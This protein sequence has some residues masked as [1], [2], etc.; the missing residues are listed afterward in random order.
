MEG[1]KAP[2]DAAKQRPFFYIMLDKEVFGQEQADGSFCHPIYESDGRLLSAAKIT[3]NVSDP[4]IFELLQTAEGFRKLVHSIGVSIETD[5]VKDAAFAFQLYGKVDTY[6]G[7]TNFTTKLKTDGVEV[8]VNLEDFPDS[9]DEKCPGQIRFNFF[10]K[11]VLAHVSVRLFLN[12]G[13]NAPEPVADNPVDTKSAA[14]KEMISHSL[15]YKGNTARLKNVMDRASKGE[16]VTLAYLGGSITQ[17]AGATPINTNCY[18]YKSFEKF[19]EIT[20]SGDNVR[21]VKAGV[22][23][24]P[25]EL[26]IVRFERDVIRD[27]GILPDMVVVE[28]AVN[29]AGDETKGD[30]FESLI[31]KILKLPNN[32]AVIILFAVFADDFNLQERLAPVGYRYHVPMVS[33]KNAVT[34]QFGLKPENGRVVSRSRYFYDCFHPTNIGHTIMSDSIACLFEAAMDSN[35]KDETEELLKGAPVIGNTFEDIVLTDKK[36]TCAYASINAGSF[37]ETDKVLQCVEK[38][39]DIKATP[40]FEFNW[41]YD[42]INFKGEYKP[43]ELEIECKSLMIVFKDSGDPK[44]GV[45]KAVVDGE[46]EIELD[47]HISGWVHCNP[48]ILTMGNE[49]R[50]HNV[51]LIPKEGSER[52]LFTILGFGYTR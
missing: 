23:G 16:K 43:F 36:A 7:G 40:E 47:P 6:G 33:V 35:D 31:K 44:V 29:D 12:D 17:G 26:G 24:T 1:P 19:K 18:A 37:T 38:D 13:F 41:M 30:C 14:Y 45:F 50:K 49:I 42:G 9:G 39:L 32:P 27:E 22:G 21:Y 34:P 48:V 8:R 11:G 2:K 51:K 28:F 46:K 15:M 52:K 20:K 25:S 3:G 10:E 4:Q 5:D